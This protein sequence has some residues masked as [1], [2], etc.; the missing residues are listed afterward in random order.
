M[1]RYLYILVYLGMASM[2]SAQVTYQSPANNA[3]FIAIERTS[4]ENDLVFTVDDA[5]ITE[6]DVLFGLEND[7]NLTSKPEYLIKT[8]TSVTPGQYTVTLETELT[9][10]LQHSKEYYWK[11]LAYEPNDVGVKLYFTGPVWTFKAI[12]DGPYLGP[13]DP[14]YKGVSAGENAVFTVVSSKVDTFQWYKEG[15]PDIALSDSDPAYSGVTTDTLTVYNVQPEKEGVYYCVGTETSSGKQT[16]SEPGKLYIK[17]LK[18]HFEFNSNDVVGDITPDSIGGVQAKLIGGASVGSDPNI[19]VGDCL[20]LNNPG[21]NEEDTQYVQILDPNVFDYPEITISAWFRMATL[22]RKAPVWAVGA[23]NGNF[24]YF[25]P[26]YR[27]DM[28]EYDGL[29]AARFEF[30]AGE[31]LW[32][33]GG[34]ELN[35]DQWYF[36]TVT[37]SDPNTGKLYIDGEYLDTDLVYSTLDLNK[38][39]AYIGRRID[40]DFGSAPLFDGFIDELKIYNY[41]LSTEEI[42]REYMAVRTDVEYVCNEE[43]YDLGNY[44]YDHNC[45][46]DLADF[47]EIIAEWLKD[48]KIS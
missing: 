6:V 24:M 47:A 20:K 43:I 29:D 26:Y 5:A 32:L 23:D 30:D 21:A 19:I 15:N 9:E 41:V 7:P 25:Y 34:Y 17:K 48:F 27:L 31:N 18:H 38:T 14:A 35:E 13:V 10:D 33:E 1:K 11:V 36:V 2:V 3:E 46:V 28:T 45:R 42:A 12:Q 37:L 4:S 44:D 39:F 22:D 16:R 40:A 8:I